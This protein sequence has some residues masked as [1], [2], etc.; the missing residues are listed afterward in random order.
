MR[1]LALLIVGLASLASL[2]P[3]AAPAGADVTTR[4]VVSDLGTLGGKE[5]YAAAINSKGQ[6]VGWAR[7]TKGKTHPFLWQGGR[8]RDLGTLGYPSAWATDVNERGQ[9]VGQVLAVG[10]EDGDESAPRGLLWQ[11]GAMVELWG[12][13]DTFADE[14]AY[15]EPRTI[16]DQGRIVGWAHT[17]DYS[18]HAMSWEAPTGKLPRLILGLDLSKRQDDHGDAY[19][20]NER[21]QI[22]GERRTTYKK[23]LRAV[24]WEKGAVVTLGTL[25]GRTQ[26]SAVAVNDRGLIVG[27]SFNRAGEYGERMTATR[28]FLWRQGKMIDLGTVGGLPHSSAVA[29]NERGQVIGWSAKSLG[30]DEELPRSPRAF[31]WQD[32]RLT[33]LGT[34]GGESAIPFAINDAGQVVGQSQ[35]AQGEWHAFVWQKGKMAALPTL[36]GTFSAALAINDAGRIIGWSRTPKDVKHAVL[37]RLKR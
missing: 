15:S 17:D 25:P 23:P 26:S 6:V 28:A 31:L 20:A 5:S 37:W 19:D 22:V 9:V 36:G 18:W 1:V 32:G 11:R 21:G 13:H 33:D 14:A 3:G 27:S 2:V 29:L 4:W 34:L 8:M 10:G 30:E 7:T 16:N 24:V 12:D 35:N